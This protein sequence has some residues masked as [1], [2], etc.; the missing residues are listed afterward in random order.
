[1]D[2]IFGEENF[3]NEIIWCYSGPGYGQ[4][5]FVRKHDNIYLY[6]KNE[7]YYFATQYIPYKAEV[8]FMSTKMVLCELLEAVNY[9]HLKKKVLESADLDPERGKPAEDWW[10]DI[11]A[12]DRMKIAL[13][14]STIQRK[15]PKPYSNA[16]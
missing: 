2:E 6:S 4:D 10:T 14:L 15:S 13:N 1:M 5:R 16:L 9:I 11:Y 3:V 7:N 8:E 12:G